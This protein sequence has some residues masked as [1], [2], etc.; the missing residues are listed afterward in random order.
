MTC[1][2]T[3]NNIHINSYTL[4]RSF[5]AQQRDRAS[6]V[7][8]S[9]SHASDFAAGDRVCTLAVP[10]AGV[11]LMVKM[12][13]CGLVFALRLMHTMATQLH[14]IRIVPGVPEP[15][16]PFPVSGPA[17]LQTV[18]GKCHD[19]QQHPFTYTV[20]PYHNV[21][22][23]LSYSS[24]KG[25]SFVL[26]VWESLEYEGGAVRGM[27]FTR[28]D[29][30]NG[31]PRQTYMQI[32]CG[33]DTWKA[34]DP[35]EPTTCE[36]SVVLEVPIACEDL[37]DAAAARRVAGGG[38]GSNGASSSSYVESGS[39]VHTTS[40]SGSSTE[41]A[42]AVAEGRAAD[43]DE[44]EDGDG[45]CVSWRQAGGCRADG[46]RESWADKSCHYEVPKGSSGFCECAGG[47]HEA[48]VSCDHEPFLCKDKCA[49]AAARRRAFVSDE[50]RNLHRAALA[51]QRKAQLARAALIDATIAVHVDQAQVES[52]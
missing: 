15:P 24:A 42:G 13:L 28:G 32:E 21:T 10:D 11:R 38:S 19:V 22:Q 29:E 36:Y 4:L 25:S 52:A 16:Q 40:S 23:K 49:A 41:A 18:Q 39:H 35:K 33:K 47:K 17:V 45:G 14:S 48:E 20:C 5:R 30:C 27:R 43:R 1:I 2:R 26:G 50:T 12:T 9:R 7:R 44:D 8:G 6:S 31:K 3:R 46:P 37:G 51:L 34:R